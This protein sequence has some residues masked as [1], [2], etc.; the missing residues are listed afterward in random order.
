MVEDGN[1]DTPLSLAC[2]GFATALDWGG[3][4]LAGAQA[5][6]PQAHRRHLAA[7]HASVLALV[8][9]SPPGALPHSVRHRLSPV[10][11]FLAVKLQQA[12]AF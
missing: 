4:L 11:L 12:G 8:D 2:A 7:K 6:S 3:R 10:A 9:A 1:G 5:S